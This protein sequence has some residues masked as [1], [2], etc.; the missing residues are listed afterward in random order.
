MAD[1]DVTAD[2]VVRDQTGPGVSSA[3][4]RIKSLGDDVDRVNKKAESGLKALSGKLGS[5]ITDGLAKTVT[6]LGA[7]VAKLG[8][9]AGQDIA[10]GIAESIQGSAP[11][12]QGAVTAVLVGAAVTAAPLIAATIAGAVTSTAALGGL[13]VGIAAVASDVRIAAAGRRIGERLLGS[14]REA[15]GPLIL[16]VVAALN[17]LGDAGTR[18]IGILA[19]GFASLARYIGP[20]VDGI[21]EAGEALARGLV[22]SMQNAGP[23]LAAIGRGIAE[24]G[25]AAEF[26]LTK[27]AAL[28]PES[29]I[30]FGGLFKAAAATVKIIAEVIF[31]ISVFAKQ[32]VTLGGLLGDGADKMAGLENATDGAATGL[33]AFTGAASGAGTTAGIAASQLQAMANG[34]SAVSNANVGADEALIRYNNS[35]KAANET[36]EAGAQFTDNERQALI[37]L[38]GA[39]EGQISALQAQGASTDEINTKVNTARLSFIAQ[40]RQMG[41]NQKQAEDLAAQYGLFPR[42]VSTRMKIIGASEAQRE[43]ERTRAKAGEIPP[44]INIAIRVTGSSA[45]RQAIAAAVAKQSLSADYH[46]DMAK[47]AEQFAIGSGLRTGPLAGASVRNTQPVNVA[48]QVTVLLDGEP[49]RATALAVSEQVNADSEW[50]RKRTR[51]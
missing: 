24:L 8:I 15:A 13:A 31:Q 48:S 35:L 3:S 19:P 2:I 10:G 20:L 14:L 36:R 33:A 43:L 11:Q 46:P 4:R 5:G 1:R 45:S 23:L 22:A 27:F 17:K 47:H 12:V 25:R 51:R 30:V 40:A 39:I 34:F 26:A 29:A 38:R 41:L 6:A 9:K 50:K 44:L 18:A 49:V 7:G 21:S 16:P 42:E 37:N 28:G 32:V